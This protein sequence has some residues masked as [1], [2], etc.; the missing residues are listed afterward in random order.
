MQNDGQL[1]KILHMSD[2]KLEDAKYLE[3]RKHFV[4]YPVKKWAVLENLRQNRNV[5]KSLGKMKI[6]GFLVKINEFP[7]ASDQMTQNLV[8]TEYFG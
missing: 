1:E 7:E 5:Q 2:K 6:I 8:A 3:Q 4:Y